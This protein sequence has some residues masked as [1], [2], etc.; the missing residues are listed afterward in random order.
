LR[1]L[2][3][4]R[5]LSRFLWYCKYI[6][7]ITFFSLLPNLIERLRPR[8]YLRSRRVRTAIDGAATYDSGHYAI[9][10]IFQPEPLPSYIL[11]AL[12]A[13]NS[14]RIN[15]YVVSNAP[16]STS[17]LDTLC[18]Y[19]SRIIVR[20]GSGR[21]F[22]S[23]KDAIAGLITCTDLRRLMLFN[24]SVYLLPNRATT[25]LQQMFPNDDAIVA[26][27]ENFQPR[28]HLQSFALSL[29]ASVVAH[30]AFRAFWRKYKPLTP[31]RYVI[32]RGEIG[33]SKA[34]LNTG[35]Q[36]R[37]IYSL[38]RLQQEIRRLGAI[39]FCDRRALPKSHRDLLPSSFINAA[40][41]QLPNAPPKLALTYELAATICE[42]IDRGPQL[43]NGGFFFAQFLQGALLKRDI[44][45]RGLFT[46]NEV[47]FF[48]QQLGL[49]EHL[50]EYRLDLLRKGTRDSLSWI[51]KIKFD[52]GIV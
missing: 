50:Q 48:L 14:E 15:T 7:A 25:L 36:V 47:L 26:T 49:D 39:A 4:A 51:D 13:L 2:S 38:Q 11:E 35:A 42:A 21:D 43:N 8:T 46:H 28:W 16:L 29:P 27:N 34:L 40:N 33:L 24:D 31:R 32:R 23:Y 30:P 10:A 3:V 18:R 45:Y 41:T 6:V 17:Q 22:G 37:V 44:V 9:Y 12:Q 20:N 5:L 19:A 52:F 1:G